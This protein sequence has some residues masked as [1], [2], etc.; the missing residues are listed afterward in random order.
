MEDSSKEVEEH[1]T[2]QA[3][4]LS[5]IHAL[6]VEL[7]ESIEKK[8]EVSSIVAKPEAFSSVASFNT[9]FKKQ[10]PPKFRGDCLEYIEFKKRWKSEISSHKLTAD[11]EIGL[12]KR[13]IPEEGKIKLFNVESM[14]T[15]WNQLDKVY[16][17]KEVIC[18][19]LK[20]KLKT[21]HPKSVDNHEIIIEIFNQMEYIVKRMNEL[22]A[23]ALLQFDND[24][25]NCC[26]MVLPCEAQQ[27][28]DRYD[29]TS[30]TN[31]WDAFF[32]FMKQ[33]CDFALNKRALTESLK[34]LGVK[35]RKMKTQ[36]KSV[37]SLVVTTESNEGKYQCKVCHEKHFFKDSSGKLRPSDRFF[38]C[39]K[40]RALSCK[41]RAKTL[42]NNSACT[43]CTSWAHGK[44]ACKAP[45]VSCKEKVDG[46]TCG[47]DHSR[48]VCGSGIAYCMSVSAADSS[49]E[50][51]DEGAPTIS[52]LQD[53]P[54]V[55]NENEL[56]SA[57]AVWDIGSNRVL[58]NTSFAE[59]IGLPEKTTSITM[60]L[61]G[62][63]KK[64]LEVKLY[65]FKVEDRF[66]IR[67]QMWGY[68]IDSIIE[69][70]E[71]IDP[72]PIRHLFPHVPTATFKKL[73]K[74]RI[75][76][77]IGLNFNQLFPT[78]GEGKDSVGNMKVLKTKFGETGWI[79]GGTHP[80][81]K[82]HCPRYSVA[83]REI[84]VA[85]VEISPSLTVSPVDAQVKQRFHEIVSARV[86]TEKNIKFWES[87]QLGVE[88]PRRCQRCRQCGKSGECSDRHILYTMKEEEELRILDE[89]VCLADG[90]VKVKYPLLKDPSCFR[91]N[92][93]DVV[94]IAEHIWKQLKCQGHLETYHAEMKKFIE[95][96][97]FVQLTAD[98]MDDY[99]GPVN[100]ISHH[101]VL[102]DSASTPLRVVTNSSKK[103]GQ[104]SLNDLLPKG[105]NSLNDML[106]VM[107]RFRAYQSAFVF[108][109]SK[110][111]NTMETHIEERH[112][113]RFVWRWSE[114]SPWIDFGIDKVH[115]GD[116]SAACQLELSKKKVALAGAHIDKEASQK[117]I[118]DGYVDDILSGGSQLAVRRM[119]GFKSSDGTY[120]GTMAKILKL[121]NF[122]A[123]EYLIEGD[124]ST[125]EINQLNNKLF[126]YGYDHENGLLKLKISLNLNKKKRN[127]RSGPEIK[128]SDL[129]LLNNAKMTKRNL[130]GLTNSFGDFLG[131]AE[132]FTLRFKLLMKK[133][134]DREIP[135]L[136][137]EPICGE[138]KSEWISLIAEAVM[139]DMLIFPRRSRPVNAVGAP[140]VV[141]FGD[142]S[143][144]AFGGCVYLVWKV[145]CEKNCPGND[146]SEDC[147][148]RFEAHL[149]LGKSRV[150][151]L[152]GFTVPRAEL[153]GA[154]LTSR[155]IYRV[156]RSLQSLDTPPCSSIELL[157]SECTIST[158]RN[159]ST[160]LRPF[161]NNRK[162]EILEN[163]EKINEMCEVEDLHWISTNDNVAD[164]L[165]RGTTKL[166]DIGPN[167][168]WF[169]GPIFL[170][171]RRMVWPVKKDFL[172]KKL[173]EEE[174]KSLV[175]IAAIRMQNDIKHGTCDVSTLFP[176]SVVEDILCKSNDLES[177]KRVIARV[178]NGWKTHGCNVIDAVKKT[179]SSDDLI[180]A[181]K[182]ILVTGMI[183]TASALEEG[184]LV[185]LLPF[186]K[187]N[188][189]VTRGRLGEPCLNPL[190]GVSEL[191]I[192]LPESRVA[193][194]FMWRAHTGCSG[195]FHR[196]V[197]QT[198]AKSRSYVW[199]VRG[200]SLAKRICNSCMICRR[201][202]KKL[203]GQQMAQLQEETVSI[204]PPW[205]FVS[206]DYAGPVSIKG[207]INTRSRG[208][209]WILVYVCKSTKA[210][211]LLLTSGYDTASFLTK[212]EEF[213]ARVG[214]QKTITTD[215]GTQL[216]R[217]GI[218][219]EKHDVS[220]K[221]W[222]WQEVIQKNSTT[223]WEFVPIGSA[224][225]NGLAES[226]VKIL[227]KSLRIALGSGVELK[228]SEMVTL[229]A[230]ISNSINS[231]PLGI[232]R[233]GASSNQEDFLAPITP[234]QLLLGRSEGNVPP[235]DYQFGD[236]FT[237]RLAYVSQVYDAWWKAWIEQVLPSLMPIS[238][239]HKR[240]KNLQKG[241][242]VM[243]YYSGNLKDEYRLAKVFDTHPDKKG[244]VR[245]VTIG[246]RKRNKTEKATPYKVKP[247]VMEKVAV[248]RLHLLVAADEKFN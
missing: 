67:T 154:L 209:G 241:D 124:V 7:A 11:F 49:Y 98:E 57:R 83:A 70:E 199:I 196:S 235:L 237:E 31:K 22:G 160:I 139:G 207:E 181:E 136:W 238:R 92:R 200:R 34:D 145:A 210:V 100:Y 9:Y 165:T 182:F 8:K 59:E 63:D 81:L 110:A 5:I 221:H 205:T 227:K 50:S 208:K 99:R 155:L 89:N 248:Q 174:I 46:N 18:Q 72:G 117:L 133:L 66:G 234:N 68:G 121:G 91:N 107:V 102:K 149:V 1:E 54:V 90:K 141:G 158:L 15:A 20:T 122:V 236:K 166:D 118:S 115:F 188:L 224:H 220:P 167:S 170:S 246:Y 42:E 144:S 28:W 29:S 75:D 192:L 203:L 189:I 183:Q 97:T 33:E 143:E 201:E 78:G 41:Q 169:R 60:N 245:T 53:I 239:W 225:R 48:L 230:K 212:H 156:V 219:L 3:T 214:D 123:K 84:R 162:S 194:L 45:P 130:L 150:S 137:D 216:I 213:R 62:G 96:G 6:K 244:L 211:C 56:V 228:Y 74:R 231:R 61:A 153:S 152:T 93:E 4:Q 185:S 114:D 215:R 13:N 202:S 132:P 186:R 146:H 243:L 23:S 190:L 142:G 30:F 108:D 69:A 55:S 40:F 147:P 82:S 128:K 126:G 176:F 36:I 95:K 163:F 32:A 120:N 164:I 79:L 24:F 26:Y 177:R 204:C 191:P 197:A 65:D 187:G 242:V 21:L 218:V 247:L 140:R 131:V 88:P 101:G 58:I 2:W 129:E 173:P 80:L 39:Q 217:G 175:R 206:L 233:V 226:T 127:V 76:L 240:A 52:Y 198:L 17:D 222:D 105:P 159:S 151:P 43:R 73:Q 104:Y 171:F 168:T 134:F 10:D 161:F 112:L 179:P 119:V 87:D 125:E 85:K 86:V 25:W 51:L 178:L 193:E 172:I 113:R 12:L 16:G 138:I 44:S 229:L 14:D 232:K 19:K 111:Y 180:T 135:L 157:D 47:L 77:L 37:D 195:L 109:L 223:K 116:R 106:E 38:A 148:G 184:K 94:R 64:R 35:D 27:Q 71:P 103:N